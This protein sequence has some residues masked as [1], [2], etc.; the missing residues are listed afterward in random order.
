MGS[1]NDVFY[2]FSEDGDSSS[3]VQLLDF[4]SSGH[5]LEYVISVVIRVFIADP[6]AW[7]WV[8]CVVGGVSIF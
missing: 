4:V 8:A 1:S 3:S 2:A 5:Y 7:L 6:I